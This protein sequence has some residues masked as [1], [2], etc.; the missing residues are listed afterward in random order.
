[1]KGVWWVNP[2]IFQDTKENPNT[3]CNIWF[4]IPSMYGIFTLH[5]PTKCKV[6]IP[7]M[8]GMG[9]YPHKKT[10]YHDD[11]RSVDAKFVQS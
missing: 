4:P 5:L 1:M 7:Y 8:D 11:G 6:N 9:F 3:Q 10:R 2:Q